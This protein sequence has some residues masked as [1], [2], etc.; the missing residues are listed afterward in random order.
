[1]PWALDGIEQKIRE[2]HTKAKALQQYGVIDLGI[3]VL[4]D[5]KAGALLQMG[6]VAWNAMFEGVKAQPGNQGKKVRWILDPAVPTHCEASANRHGC[7]DLAKTYD[8]WDDLPTLPA[9][10]VTCIGNCILP[11]TVVD[12]IDIE[13]LYRI[14]YKGKALKL[15]TESGVEFTVT[16]NHPVLTPNGWL[17]A[18]L[19][20]PG[21]EV[22]N[23]SL[24]QD[25]VDSVNNNHKDMPSVIEEIWRAKS[26]L[27]PVYTTP[28]FAIMPDNFHSDG[29][30]VNGN[31]DIIFGDS[32]LGREV[33]NTSMLENT[34]KISLGRGLL[35]Q[36]LLPADRSFFKVCH[37]SVL[38]PDSIMTCQ[39]LKLPLLNGHRLPFNKFGLALGTRHDASS[40]EGVLD[41][42]SAY[43]NIMRQLIETYSRKVTL[44]KIVKVVEFDYV[45]HVYDLQTKDGYYILSMSQRQGIVNSNCRCSLQVLEEKGWFDPLTGRYV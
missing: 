35:A 41:R 4:F 19:L 3:S 10:E 25:S 13:V 34:N 14:P 9:G 44:D 11:G 37:P 39:D 28:Q 31:I 43:T 16:A 2:E 23:S 33:G 12:A 5:G 17:T 32:Q 29:R 7:I 36:G 15:F 20:H 40:Y 18:N 26:I 6:G 27:Y 42:F 38:A 8:S 45:G 24:R 22:V 30:F 1:M 21:D